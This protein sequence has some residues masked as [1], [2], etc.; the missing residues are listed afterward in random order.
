MFKNMASGPSG[1][2]IPPSGNSNKGK[3]KKTYVVKLMTRFNNEIGS[4]SQPTTPTSTSTGRSVP[5]PL[6]VPAFTPTPHQ[7]PTS[8]PTSIGTSLPPPIQVPGLTPTPYQVPPYLQ[9]SLSPNVGSNPSTPRNIAASPGIEDADPHSSSAANN[10]EECSNSRPMITP[11]GGGFYPTKTA[12]K[13]I[14]ATIKEQFDEP[15]L[16]WGAIPKSTRDVFFERFKRRVSWKPED[17]EKVKKNYHTKASHRLSEM[18]KKARTLGKRPDWL[19]DDTWNALLEKWNMPLYRQKCE[20]AKKNRTSEKGGCLHTRGSISVH[21]HAIRLS[22]ELGRSVHVDEIFQQTHIRQSTGEFVDERSRR[23][24]EQFVAKFSQIR[25]ETA[26]VGVSTSSPLDPAE[27]EILRNRCWLEAA[28][29]KYKGRVYGIGNVTSQDDCVDSYIQQT[30]ASSI[31]QPQNSEEILN[32]KSQ[33]QQYGQQLQ[34]LEG[35]IGVLLP[36]LPPSAATAAQQFL[37]LQ[38]PQVQNDV[39]NIVQPE[40]QPPEQQPPHQQPPD[41]QPQDGNDYMHY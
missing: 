2:P 5:P 21:E 28:G 41:E 19:G 7:V 32:L 33:L 8:S 1:P 3:G 30:Q 17:E 37:N 40:Q 10:M 4:T 38:N 39:P 20:T 22:Q 25:S 35:F 12:S 27:E 34:N 11:V 31:A 16:T 6:V 15:W 9:A 36:F 26:S 14:T 18:Y 29:G 23:T 24:H 13:A